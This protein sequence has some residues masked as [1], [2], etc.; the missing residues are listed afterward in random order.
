MIPMGRD[1][2]AIAGSGRGADT[3]VVLKPAH[4]SE[5]FDLCVREIIAKP[6]TR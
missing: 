5:M 2:I 6:R 1:I 3:A 4:Q